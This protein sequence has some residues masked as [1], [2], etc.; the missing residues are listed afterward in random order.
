M[1]G[2]RSSYHGNTL[3]ALEASGKAPLRK[4]YTPWLGRFLHAGR[5]RVSVREPEHPDGCGA[6]RAAE[7]GRM[8]VLRPE[9]V[10]AFVGEP[11]VGATL[12][13]A[14]PSEDYWAAIAE[15]CRRTTSS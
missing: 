2:R 4:P 14:V 11:M 12:G 1:I 13:A 7:L 15:V 8:L 10:A 3:G 6:W 5:L 9:T